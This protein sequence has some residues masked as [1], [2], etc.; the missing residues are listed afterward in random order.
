MATEQLPAPGLPANTGCLTIEFRHVRAASK[1][2]LTPRYSTGTGEFAIGGGRPGVA[3]CWLLVD[4][5]ELWM[6]QLHDPS[7]LASL[8]FWFFHRRW[9]RLAGVGDG[10]P[11]GAWRRG[12]AW[13]ERRLDFAS[14][15]SAFNAP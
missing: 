4:V 7:V 6:H 11:A 8:T 9:W 5:V 12:G 1:V 13:Q 10:V 3:R 14:A 2:T 15:G